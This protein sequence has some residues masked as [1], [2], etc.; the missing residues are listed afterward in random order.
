MNKP[1][2]L[3][4]LIASAAL[5]A[6]AAPASAQVT[7][8]LINEYPATAISGE[9]DA[10]FAAAVERRSGGRVIIRIIPD[11]KSGLRSRDQLKAVTDGKFALAD[12]VGG[13]LGEES[14]V[15]LLSSLPFVT[16]TVDEARTL[17]RLARPLYE[18]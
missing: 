13:T 11:A 10:Y 4:K 7:L 5:I 17:Y 3:V 2:K 12:S 6:I 8:D 1:A 16:P 14:P 9:A 18:Q 15:F